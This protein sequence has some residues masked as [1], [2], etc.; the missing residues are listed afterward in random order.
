VECTPHAHF[1]QGDAGVPNPIFWKIENSIV[2]TKR[3]NYGVL[4]PEF[5][6]T[7]IP[8]RERFGRRKLG[9]MER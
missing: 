8:G 3:M 6:Q 2:L 9:K 7:G 4:D 5:A 1:F